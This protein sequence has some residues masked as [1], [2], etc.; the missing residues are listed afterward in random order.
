VKADTIEP[1]TVVK[2]KP[3]IDVIE[4]YGLDIPTE[5]Y[6]TAETSAN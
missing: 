6:E 1:A 5:P 2:S 4:K 3:L